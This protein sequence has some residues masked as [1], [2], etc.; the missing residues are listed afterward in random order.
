MAGLLGDQQPAVG[1]IG[2]GPGIVELAQALDL[3]LAR[4]Q[5]QVLGAGRTDKGES[6]QAHGQQR[7][8]VTGDRGHALLLK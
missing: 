3:E 4:G 8:A 5:R 6:G 2:H 1:Q 7:Q